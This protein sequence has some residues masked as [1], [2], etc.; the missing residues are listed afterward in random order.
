MS[1]PHFH[2][3]EIHVSNSNSNLVVDENQLIHFYS[4]HQMSLLL[5]FFPAF[6]FSE[7]LWILSPV[8]YS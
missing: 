6:H 5:L 8:R 2:V 4:I 1:T 7:I 3:W